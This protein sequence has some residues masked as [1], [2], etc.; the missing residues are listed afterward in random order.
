MP[1]RDCL[2]VYFLVRVEF[3]PKAAGTISAP[4]SER[5]TLGTWDRIP[6]LVVREIAPFEVKE[7]GVT[8]PESL[9]VG[10]NQYY[11]RSTGPAERLYGLIAVA[12][13]NPDER[14]NE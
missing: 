9:S 8:S 14:M 6:S 12:C 3:S 11:V 2:F 5:K 1:L 13:P 7:F 10:S 4:S